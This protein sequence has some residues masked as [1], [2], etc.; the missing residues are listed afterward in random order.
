MKP[1]K[2]SSS[3]FNNQKKNMKIVI[4]L[5]FLFNQFSLFSQDLNGL[6]E[7]KLNTI[8][9]ENL[10]F[11][12]SKKDSFI[13]DFK[14]F[15]YDVKNIYNLKQNKQNFINEILDSVS[16]KRFMI[17]EIRDLIYFKQNFKDEGYIKMY[18]S[19][20][21]NDVE[22]YLKTINDLNKI[23]GL[24]K[25]NKCPFARSVKFVVLKAL[26]NDK[27]ETLKK[28]LL[29]YKKIGFR[30][31][32]ICETKPFEIYPNNSLKYLSLTGAYCNSI[33]EIVYFENNSKKTYTR[34]VDITA[35][36]SENDVLILSITI[37]ENN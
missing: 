29:N 26:G 25:C 37:P 24:E 21:K 7:K 3:K 6:S 2:G 15:S 35:G 27:Q 33:V 13:N 20:N 34:Q 5:L 16:K 31:K 19:A 23:N 22:K 28:C 32:P 14:F 4:I 11:F 30:G 18:L 36:K 10:D 17:E 12:F 8:Y 1:Y 9:D